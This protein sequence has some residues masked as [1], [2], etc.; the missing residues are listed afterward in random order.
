MVITFTE[1]KQK[2]N[3][4]DDDY[5]NVTSEK[6]KLST[7]M[8]LLTSITSNVIFIIVLLCGLMYLGGI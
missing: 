8:M 6:I 1:L 7:Q 2:Y 3:I 5:D 4:S